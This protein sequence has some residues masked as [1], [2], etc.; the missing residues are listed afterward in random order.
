VG[1]SVKYSSSLRRRVAIGSGLLLALAAVQVPL[2]VA[3]STSGASATTTPGVVTN[4]TRALTA[5]WVSQNDFVS[6][7]WA[8]SMAGKHPAAT[9][10]L[11]SISA[12]IPLTCQVDGQ[13][14]TVA[15][16]VLRMPD[17]AQSFA[18]NDTA[19][20]PTSSAADA[21]GYQVSVP[22]GNLC[23][24]GALTPH[25]N[26]TYT[27]NLVST[28]THDVFTMRFHT[29][30]ARTNQT[31]SKSNQVNANTDC[32]ST[33]NDSGVAQC[34]AAWTP[35]TTSA[36]TAPPAPSVAVKTVVG[37]VTNVTKGLTAQSVS[38]G[39]VVSS[40]WAIS[41]PGNHPSTT[42][43]LSNISATI[44]LTCQ[45]SGQR[46][47]VVNLLI[48]MPDASA[49]IPANDTAWHPTSSAA[50]GAGYQASVPVGDL[51]HAGSL[52][53]HGNATYTAKLASSDT[54][55]L[56]A[57]RFHSVDAR[58]NQTNASTGNQVN[59]NTDCAGPHNRDALAQCTAAWTVQTTAAAIAQVTTAVGGSGGTV[60]G[61]VAS[62]GNLV[63]L[64]PVLHPVTGALLPH[65]TTGS[66]GSAS[67]AG[68]PAA[69][70][71]GAVSG[72]TTQPAPVL[73]LPAPSQSTV[74]GPVPLPV[75]V[76]D[77]VAAGVG[78]SLPWKWFL[79]L[80]ILDLGLIVGIVIRR[81]SAQRDRLN[82]Q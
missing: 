23:H 20:H 49:T 69:S 42:V 7:G 56:F 51:C 22:V 34:N 31:S 77:S 63:T 29:V 71:S 28:D 60:G 78:G 21:H 44:P 64:P 65:R 80:A 67:V 41:M 36:A 46:S 1:T 2:A 43:T 32:T 15:S 33:Q 10:Q 55:D 82:A 57:L 75:P 11:T 61:L 14:P 5:Q 25:G 66:H 27:A 8:I 9:V 58:T 12:T 68:A 26:A 62:I 54:T 3:A 17:T 30:D 81:R 74:L 48:Q 79:L 39:D 45:V 59:P 18:T 13:H 53:P 19:W 73:V 47:T 24:N 16:L 50:D 52:T 4:V 40:G 37:L 6:S 76:I 38:P 35:L 70:S 72:A